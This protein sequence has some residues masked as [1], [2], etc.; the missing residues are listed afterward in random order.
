MNTPPHLL[1]R[2]TKSPHPSIP[3][4]SLCRSWPSASIPPP[5]LRTSA[6]RLTLCSPASRTLR[7]SPSD[8]S[9]VELYIPTH[10]QPLPL[11]HP[12]RPVRESR[13]QLELSPSG[14]NPC[15]DLSDMISNAT[16]T[17]ANRAASK[18]AK[19]VKMGSP[20]VRPNS[21]GGDVPKQSHGKQTRVT[22]ARSEDAVVARASARTTATSKS[23]AGHPRVAGSGRCGENV[24]AGIFDRPPVSPAPSFLLEM[25][26]SGFDPS[27]TPSPPPREHTNRRVSASYASSSATSSSTSSSPQSG[28]GWEIP[29]QDS[30]ETSDSS[31]SR[32]RDCSPEQEPQDVS[33]VHEDSPPRPPARPGPP[34]AAKRPSRPSSVMP[35]PP[36][37]SQAR[38]KSAEVAPSS[39]F[40]VSTPT[41]SQ[42]LS[43]P[44][45][46]PSRVPGS[47]QPERVRPS[48][49]HPPPLG[50]RPRYG[51]SS[52][53]LSSTMTKKFKVPFAKKPPSAQTDTTSPKQKQRS[54]SP[55]I[56]DPPHIATL[57]HA[58]VTTRS[59]EPPASAV[60]LVMSA[61]RSE[62]E[63]DDDEFKEANSS[64]DLW[65]SVPSLD[66]IGD[67]L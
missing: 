53:Y 3:L 50:M 64:A 14:S 45:V 32:T 63:D 27:S 66:D 43:Q 11:N 61:R 28:P 8:H 39:S 48:S 9:P 21:S 37:P 67:I 65:A 23:N 1:L 58:P 6:M 34:P 22:R 36:L 31:V 26:K 24:F 38:R 25:D 51:Q 16:I 60:P 47:S 59:A 13:A 56:P 10:R 57:A 42:R 41:Q 20:S 15:L 17:T 7:K 33:M 12:A 49:Q 44:F 52:S 30:L 29:R 55:V 54:L 46:P 2:T 40:L 62:P 5:Q 18:A 35:P 4:S 19:A